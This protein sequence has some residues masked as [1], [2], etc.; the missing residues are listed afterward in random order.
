MI[1]ELGFAGRTFLAEFPGC[2]HPEHRDFEL[3]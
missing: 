1:Q 3:G 2:T